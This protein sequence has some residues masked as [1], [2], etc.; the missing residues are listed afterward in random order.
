MQRCLRRGFLSLLLIA[1]CSLNLTAADELTRSTA[2]TLDADHPE[3]AKKGLKLFREQV[4]EILAERCLECHGGG[5]IKA[6]FSLATRTQLFESGFVGETAAESALMELIRHETEPFMPWKKPQLTAQEIAAVGQ[7]IDLGAPYDRP[8]KAGAASESGE[9]TV[10]DADRSFWSFGPIR[11]VQPPAVSSPDW[12]LT[13]IDQFVLARLEQAGIKPNQE[14]SAE[15]LV[16]RLSFALLGLPPDSAEVHKFMNSNSAD[17]W[18]T[19]T[20]QMLRSPHY[21]ERWARHWMD[22]ARFAESHGYEQDYDRPHAY[23]YRD[24]LI[25][26][27][28]QDLPFDQF[29]S[30]QL[31]GDELA[32][33]NPLAMMATGFLGAG[34]FPT[35]LTETEFESARYDELD[36]MVMTT[37]VAFLGLSVGCARC[38]DHK[39]DPVPARDYY[40]LAAVFGRTIRSETQIDPAPEANVEKRR[41]Y[42]QQ[43]AK[44]Q[45]Q[46]QDFREHSL[47]PR[48]RIWLQE[49]TA[50]QQMQ[51]WRLPASVTVASSAGTTFQLQPDGSWLASGNAP[52]GEILTLSGLTGAGEIGSVRLEALTHSSLPHDGPGRAANGNFAL[53]NLEFR[54]SS[55]EV[56]P[57]DAGPV[58]LVNP[59]A[60]HQQNA[61][62]LSVQASLDADPVSG[63]AVDAGG[64]GKDQAAVF[65][66]ETPIADG[67]R[68]ELKL[69][70]QHPNGQHTL[71]RLRISF[72]EQGGLPAVAGDVGPPA[73]AIAAMAAIRGGKTP[74]PAGLRAAIDWYEKTDPEFLALQRQ[75][76]DLTAAG[77]PVQLSTVMVSSEGLP[78][79]KHNAD[80]RGFP[81]FYPDTW[82]LNRGDVHQKKELAQPGFLRVLSEADKSWEDWLVEPPEGSRTSFQRAT[83][84]RW[85]T[86]TQ[87]GAGGLLARVIVNRLWLHHFGEGLVSTPNDFGFSGAAPSHPELLEWL[88]GELV[89]SGWSIRHVQR[90]IVS[91]RVWKQS[92]ESDPER[93]QVDRD[94]R[95]LWHR[96]RRRLEAEALRDAML[97][98]SGRLNTAQFGPG[99]LDQSMDRRSIY[100]FIKRSALIPMMMLFDWPEHLVSIGRRPVTT[101]APQALMF[102]N[103]P[104]GRSL[105]SSFASRLQGLPAEDRIE[106]AWW[107]ALA[108]SPLP[109]EVLE[110]SSFLRHQQ[111]LYGADNAP[112]A[113][114]QLAL[115]DLCQTLFAMNEF[116]YVE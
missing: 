34:V 30:W 39:F 64:I 43:L 95:L 97:S 37:G 70:L 16:R 67:R 69:T 101:I 108:R 23:H 111:E 104:E 5:S 115:T 32:P 74:E 107:L 96:P 10:T 76:S 77:P 103:S 72:A 85:M 50:E 63:W 83:L 22:V 116:A 31:A 20:E 109:Q 1:V 7:W 79:L 54:L 88:A 13:P 82:V 73:N 21:G 12:C 99:T 59:R 87:S 44:L 78:H 42:E 93:L 57:A 90:L 102:M 62:S 106:Q 6:D 29:V 81:H 61:D 8:L 11:S 36:D 4:R 19:L 38:H 47:E 75:L 26:A 2:R 15:Q 55:D 18:A 91:S 105:A 113:A 84:A 35:Q 48:F 60:T 98:V 80:G 27:F 56:L 28:N 112:N 33:E 110:A 114:L 41:E 58:R 40:S 3:N 9:L 92:G 52:A 17:A 86:D 53:G 51:L 24:F 45:Q 49:Q 100:F 25:R 14:A 46:L 65:D 68:W 66:L 71:G 89:R 94:N